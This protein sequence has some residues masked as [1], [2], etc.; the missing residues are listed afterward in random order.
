MSD[1]YDAAA[2][3]DQT[4]GPDADVTRLAE[5]TVAIA[6]GVLDR[7]KAYKA[8]MAGD[9]TL[10]LPL[11]G[12]TVT[13]PKFRT[14]GAM[15]KAQRLAKGDGTKATRIYAVNVCRFDGERITLHDFDQLIPVADVNTLMASLFGDDQDDDLP[16]DDDGAEGFGERPQH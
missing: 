13:Y 5:E 7:L 3:A 6:G 10:T 16:E 9:E 1:N 8:S 14:N 2:T 12:V 15:M 11:T 4:T